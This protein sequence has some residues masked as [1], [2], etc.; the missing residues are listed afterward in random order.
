MKNFKIW[1]EEKE[2]IQNKQSIYGPLDYGT[3]KSWSARKKEVLDFWSS[4]SSMPLIINPIS[5]DHKGSTFGEDGIRITGSPQFIYSM[6]SRLKDFLNLESENTKLQI[7][8]KESDRLNP[9]KPNK[10]SY[11][12]YVQ[13]KQRGSRK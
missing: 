9:N 1:I 3:T 4:L 2:E 7:L 6:M 11:A 12:F 13:V 10:K 8:F 5:K